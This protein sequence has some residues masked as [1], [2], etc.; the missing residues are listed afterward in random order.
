MIRLLLADDQA[1]VRAG[2]RALLDRTADVE[3]VGEAADGRAAVELARRLR[4]DVVLMDLRM[5]A[6]DGLEATRLIAADPALAGVAVLVL[7]TFGDDEHL[8]ASLRAGASG[9][10]LKDVDAEELRAGVRTVAAGDALLSPADTKRLIAEFALGPAGGRVGGTTPAGGAA[11]DGAT[12][13][14]T[15]DGPATGGAARAPGDR[16]APLTP[17]ERELVTLVARGRSN[18]E[19]AEELTISAA[20]VKTHVNRAMAK[21]GARDRAQLVVLGYEC[22]LVER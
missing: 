19:I 17:R 9:F 14:A 11:I 22:G 10:L 4:P 21:L 5:P 13:R 2:L 20:T 6:L 1:L 16:L 15:I 3:V 18:A 12:G 7:T 8:F